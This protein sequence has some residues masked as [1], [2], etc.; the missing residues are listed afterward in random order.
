MDFHFIIEMIAVVLALS[1]IV[2]SYPIYKKHSDVPS[3]FWFVSWGIWMGT[4]S[5]VHIILSVFSYSPNVFINCSSDIERIISAILIMFCIY[6]GKKQEEIFFYF[7][8]KT[9][10][11]ILMPTIILFTFG[12]SIIPENYILTKNITIIFKVFQIY[13]NSYSKIFLLKMNLIVQ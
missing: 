11:L 6:P 3:L 1:T 13:Y 7:K 8:R 2:F 10:L 4:F 9:W 12:L 5:L